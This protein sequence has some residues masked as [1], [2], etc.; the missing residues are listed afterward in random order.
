M[1]APSNK[2]KTSKYT[3]PQTAK[4]LIATTAPSKANLAFDFAF[5]ME[6]ANGDDIHDFLDT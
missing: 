5:F 3:I 4:S 2:N 6:N 1:P